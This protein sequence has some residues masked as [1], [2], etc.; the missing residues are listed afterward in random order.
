M[1][2][3]VDRRIG[4]DRGLLRRQ[5]KYRNIGDQSFIY[6]DWEVSDLRAEDRD[7]SVIRSLDHGMPTLDIVRTERGIIDSQFRR[8][9]QKLL[10]LFAY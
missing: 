4:V 10:R 3:Q 8:H 9:R 6:C 1:N 2:I 7:Q 5:D